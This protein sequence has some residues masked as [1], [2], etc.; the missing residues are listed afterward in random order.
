MN[1]NIHLLILLLF[2]GGFFLGGGGGGGGGGVQKIESLWRM[3]ILW[4]LFGG[5]HKTRLIFGFIFMHLP[6]FLSSMYRTGIFFVGC[7][8]VV[9][10]VFFGVGGKQ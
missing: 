5:N 7:L 4:I 8:F 2:F 3:Q 6:V 9:V 10:V 1:F